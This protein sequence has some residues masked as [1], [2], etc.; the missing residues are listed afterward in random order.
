MDTILSDAVCKHVVESQWLAADGMGSVGPTELCDRGV[1]LRGISS[2]V[3]C[4]L[5]GRALL[6]ACWHF[7]RCW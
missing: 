4:R 7:S 1:L 5:S 6:A 2:D 3:A